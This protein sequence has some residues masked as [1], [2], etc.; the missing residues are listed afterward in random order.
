MKLIGD[1]G[2]VE[3]HFG[4]FRDAVSVGARLVHGLHHTYHRLSDY[5]GRTRWYSLV[6]RLRWKL[7]LVRLETLVVLGQ[8]RCMVGAKRTIGSDIILDAADGTL[9]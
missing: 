6:M 7:T 4:P 9:R 5:F 1:V 2:L 8:D 3:S